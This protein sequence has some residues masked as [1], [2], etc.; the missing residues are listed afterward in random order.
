MTQDGGDS[1]DCPG[2]TGH[3]RHK[4]P[5]TCWPDPVGESG[6]DWHH[7]A[8]RFLKSKKNVWMVINLVPWQ[9]QAGDGKLFRGA[10]NAVDPTQLFVE[11][12]NL[13]NM[14]KK[15]TKM[16]HLIA[17]PSSQLPIDSLN[18][19]HPKPPVCNLLQAIVVATHL[20]TFGF[21]H[22]SSSDTFLRH[23]FWLYDVHFTMCD[24]IHGEKA[25]M[26]WVH[27]FWTNI[28]C[29]LDP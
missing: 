24:S 11:L 25:T 7:E 12:I 3:L 9:I 15:P 20:G 6:W 16:Q 1:S 4:G 8:L 19:A 22:G 14:L 23:S 28:D 5:R 2:P 21:G 13:E 29:A 10:D 18:S 27:H 26:C 17:S